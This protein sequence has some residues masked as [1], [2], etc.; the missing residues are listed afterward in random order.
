MALSAALVGPRRWRP[1]AMLLTALTGLAITLSFTRA[2]YVSEFVAI[3]LVSLTW[4]T[5]SGWRSRRVRHTLALAVAALVVA[6][7]IAGGKS[8]GTTTSA[9]SPLQTAIGRVELG[10]SNVQGESGT[11]GYR[12]RQADRE[13]EVLGGDWVGG[14]GFLNPTYHYVDG[15]RNGSIRDSDLGSLNIVMTMGLIGLLTAYL[16]PIAGLIYLLRRRYSFVQYGGAMYLVAALVGSI[17][18]NALSSVPGLLVL[19]LMLPLCLNWTGLEEAAPSDGTRTRRHTA[20][21]AG[22][23]R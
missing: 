15:L 5:G 10:F 3:A 7:A 4:A 19:G 2:I 14:L 16:P 21:C 18:L 12:L 17:T 22:P 1:L 11:V 20:D 9:S 23:A 13:L 8:G 6:L